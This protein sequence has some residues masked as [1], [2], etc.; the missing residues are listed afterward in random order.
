MN[1]SAVVLKNISKRFGGTQALSDVSFEIAKGEV[2]AL[3]GENGAGKSTLVKIISGVIPKDEGNILV[4]GEELRVKNPQQARQKGINVVYQE[5]SLVPN[6]TVA[7]NILASTERMNKFG[8]MDTKNMPGH[9]RQVLRKFHINPSTRVRHLGIG[10]QQMVEITS[11]ISRNCKL[12]ILDEPTAALTNEEIKELFRLIGELKQQG[13][14]I[15]YISHKIS[16]ILTIAD[17]VSVLKDGLYVG[18]KPIVECDEATLISMMIGRELG[19]MY[20]P[21]GSEL[22]EIILE[23]KNLAGEGFNDVSFKLRRGEILGFAGL[24][25]AGRTELMTTIFGASK[26][27]SGDI[28][29]EGNTLKTKRPID[30]IRAGIAYLPEDRKQVAIFSQMNIKENSITAIIDS[31]AKNGVLDRKKIR[32]LTCGMIEKLRTKVGSMDDKILSLSGGNQQKVVLSRWLLSN[33]KVLIADEPTRGIDVGA[34]HEI[35]QILRGLTSKGIGIILVS[36]EL[37]EIIGMCDRVITMYRGKVVCEAENDAALT[38]LLG[39]AIVGMASETMIR[40]A[41]ERE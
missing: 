29:L 40:E 4:D 11:A 27:N 2:H 30:A 36:S 23:V 41:P 21:L 22:G 6:L 26:A 1:R 19:N 16:E 20:P 15:I 18:T 12:L 31:V 7:E 17:R 8:K 14:T 3:L 9:I 25:G 32:E 24:N 33:P 38:D 37:P 34:K 39:R 28:M 13:V 5:L 35:Y 10:M